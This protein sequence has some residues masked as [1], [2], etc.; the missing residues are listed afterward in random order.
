MPMVKYVAAHL[1]VAVQYLHENNICWTDP[2]P[3]NVIIFSDFSL[4]ITDI[5]GGSCEDDRYIDI[6]F[7]VGM[8]YFLEVSKFQ[9]I[10]IT[11][12]VGVLIYIQ[13]R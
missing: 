2:M 10:T 6:D 1:V 4:R 13:E 5:G 3:R 9:S 12:E 7:L 11:N 8:L